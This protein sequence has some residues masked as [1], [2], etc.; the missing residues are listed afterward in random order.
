[1]PIELVNKSQNI[2]TEYLISTD[3][4][5]SAYFSTNITKISNSS[6]DL[7]KSNSADGSG[8][9][10]VNYPLPL[11][12]QL[13]RG[14]THYT[15]DNTPPLKLQNTQSNEKIPDIRD[16]QGND[17]SDGILSKS[18][19]SQE[20]KK[21]QGILES[22]MLNTNRHMCMDVDS[23]SDSGISTPFSVAT[24]DIDDIPGLFATEIS[25]YDRRPY[26]EL[27]KK[28]QD[29]FDNKFITRLH[30]EDT[31][32][33]SDVE[34]VDMDE[35]RVINETKS[36]TKIGS[37]GL[38]PCI[39][40]CAYGTTDDGESILG[41]SHYS[42]ISEPIEVM[43][44][45]DYK[46]RNEG[47]SDIDYY[48][49]GGMIMPGGEESG[50]YLS[51]VGLLSLSDKFNIK[52]ARLHVSEGLEDTEDTDEFNFDKSIDIVMNS[53]GVFFRRKT[54]YIS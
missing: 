3:K 30:E 21:S 44:E 35:A 4:E 5:N 20:E 52:G 12:I 8:F 48:L 23:I 26:L 39:G 17:Y 50:S 25:E 53:E 41:L 19:Y 42:G 22:S 13:P 33:F 9:N 15:P 46:M 16:R 24:M 38:G 40:I 28:Y 36:K 18:L 34:D 6:W 29:I 2:P 51:E 27:E 1:M 32:F 7:G 49:V 45:I 31:V 37:M 43:E 14:Y 10:I 11:G 47:A 54:M